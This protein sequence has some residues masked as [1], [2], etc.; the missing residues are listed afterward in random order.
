MRACTCCPRVS[1]VALPHNHCMVE[2]TASVV[3]ALVG[4]QRASG[5]PGGSGPVAFVRERARVVPCVAGQHSAAAPRGG[6]APLSGS[7][8]CE[9]GSVTLDSLCCK[10][11]SMTFGATCWPP[12]LAS[13]CLQLCNDTQADWPLESRLIAAQ[14]YYAM[15]MRKR[16]EERVIREDR[17]AQLKPRS[18]GCASLVVASLSRAPTHRRCP[19]ATGLMRS[20]RR[21]SSCPRSRTGGWTGSTS[22]SC[23]TSTTA[24]CLPPR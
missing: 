6:C 23:W 10:S 13:L 12:R 15:F 1:G 2:L 24:S 8:C 22:S 21:G 19:H 14:A 9:S 20:S 11:V 18:K 17:E 16:E 4:V 5:A 3:L 7:L